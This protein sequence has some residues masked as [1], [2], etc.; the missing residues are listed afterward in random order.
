MNHLSPVLPENFTQLSRNITRC[1]AQHA[2]NRI[3]QMLHL[4]FILDLPVHTVSK[5]DQLLDLLLEGQL[6]PV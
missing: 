6:L 1:A 3:P 2:Q 4:S 5:S